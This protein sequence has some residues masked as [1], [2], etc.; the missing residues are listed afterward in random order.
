MDGRR[1]LMG[2]A[3]ELATLV[4]VLGVALIYLQQF[5]DAPQPIAG[6]SVL[7][8]TIGPTITTPKEVYEN[9]PSTRRV[10]DPNVL[11]FVNELAKA[12][13]KPK[14]ILKISKRRQANA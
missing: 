6:E 11:D 12:G 7:L 5:L 13:A 2:T 10:T 3:G 4:V 9:Y 8:S 14:R 1:N